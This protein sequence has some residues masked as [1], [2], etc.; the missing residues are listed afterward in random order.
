MGGDRRGPGGGL[1]INR[2]ELDPLVAAN[3]P[4]K[5]LLSKLLAVPELRA[6]YLQLMREISDKWLDWD[7]LG[8]I[9]EGYHKLIGVEVAADTRKLDS[10]ED[11]EKSLTQDIAGKGGGPGGKGTIALKNFADQRRAYVQRVLPETSR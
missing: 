10:T 9:A 8:P 3:D 7:K 5:P 4:S 2:V 1:S 6:R 11:F